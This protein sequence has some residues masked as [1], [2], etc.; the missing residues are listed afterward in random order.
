[1][2]CHWT[3]QGNRSCQDEDMQTLLS[4]DDRE[5]LND[6]EER[7][8]KRNKL[9][10][11]V[12]AVGFQVKQLQDR[13]GLA[14]TSLALAASFSAPSASALPN[15][16]ASASSTLPASSSS[17]QSASPSMPTKGADVLMSSGMP[18]WAQE[19]GMTTEEYWGGLHVAGTSQADLTG[20]RIT[21]VQ[22]TQD[23]LSF[24]FGSTD[25]NARS[26][27]QL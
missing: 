6:A 16:S 3:L 8:S 26:A 21:P 9:T 25:S 15:L 23:D 2:N 24:L 5:S 14:S 4:E 13:M 20:N 12:Q 27:H 1:M 7:A 22:V 18:W 10:E 11:Q 17:V 19:M